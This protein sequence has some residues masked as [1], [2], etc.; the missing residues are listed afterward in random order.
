[1]YQTVTSAL[2]PR[3]VV[4]E[5]LQNVVANKNKYHS[6]SNYLRQVL[7]LEYH[8]RL[9]PGIVDTARCERCE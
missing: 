3:T 8:A 1:M 5:A 4:L 6:F 9:Q 2:D 7:A